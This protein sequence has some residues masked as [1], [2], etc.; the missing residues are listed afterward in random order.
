LPLSLSEAAIATRAAA[1]PDTTTLPQPLRRMSG[2][3]LVRMIPARG[4]PSRMYPLLQVDAT[5]LI[6]FYH[7]LKKKVDP[8]FAI[9]FTR[10][11]FLGNPYLTLKAK[12][13]A[14]TLPLPV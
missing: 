13:N 14:L 9:K 2:L 7:N 1:H 10:S 8:I 12:G 11:D 3:L 5:T 4:P 6:G